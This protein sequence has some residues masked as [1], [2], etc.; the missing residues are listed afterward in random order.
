MLK[1]AAARGEPDD[2]TH[3]YEHWLVAVERLVATKRLVVPGELQQ[4]KRDWEAAYL[5]T[6]HGQPVELPARQPR[7]SAMR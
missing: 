1:E 2:G 4:R 5:T 7:I 6:P 3:Y